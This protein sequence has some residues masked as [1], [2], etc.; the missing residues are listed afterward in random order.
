MNPNIL[1]LQDQGCFNQVT[2]LC[3]LLYTGVAEGLAS[4]LNKTLNGSGS[5]KIHGKSNTCLR[6]PER[7]PDSQGK[8]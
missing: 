7:K 3:C 4:G 8:L 1:G 6:R 2:A 5:S